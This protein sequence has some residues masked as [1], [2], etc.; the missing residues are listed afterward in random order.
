MSVS[1]DDWYP[2]GTN[3]AP[4]LADLILHT[5]GADFL[6]GLLKNR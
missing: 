4:P 3:C 6:Q 5:Y 1:T 2:M